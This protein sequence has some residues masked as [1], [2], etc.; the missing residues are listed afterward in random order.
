MRIALYTAIA[1]G[2]VSV[3]LVLNQPDR[4]AQISEPVELVAQ[5]AT[6]EEVL[7]SSI[8]VEEPQ[9]PFG[10]RSVDAEQASALVYRLFA[11]ESGDLRIG[12]NLKLLFDHFLLGASEDSLPAIIANIQKQIEL[13]LPPKAQKQAL[14]ILSQ[15]I[16]MK[17]ELQ[18]A[19]QELDAAN[20]QNISD[21]DLQSTLERFR[22]RNQIRQSWLTPEVYQ[23]FYGDEAQLDQYLIERIRV[24]HSALSAGEKQDVFKVLEH[25][26][27]LD[28]QQ[29]RNATREHLEVSES[30]R[31]ARENGASENEVYSIRSQM[32]GV[33][34]AERLAELDN[35]RAA[36]KSRLDD[37]RRSRDQVLDSGGAAY[38]IDQLRRSL[39]SETELKRVTMMDR[40]ELGN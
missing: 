13:Q 37:Y 28:M 23:V 27:P 22:V 29:R 6:Q 38:E 18:D 1:L 10:P 25:N 36:W 40:S 7:I 31:H 35:Q 12:K 39:F 19:A 3:W 16:A 4:E 9:S 30:V 5:D 15:Y 2:V 8:T 26:L 33:E 20:L 32:V 11:D 14:D 34:A 24:M 21:M 17:Q